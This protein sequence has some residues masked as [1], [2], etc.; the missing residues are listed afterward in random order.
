[1][2][3]TLAPARETAPKEILTGKPTRV[4]YVV[5]LSILEAMLGRSSKHLA[6][7]VDL[8]FGLFLVFLLEPCLG[9]RILGPRAPL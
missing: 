4:L 6:M 1:M 5:T 7:L 2:P 9:G 3:L 8:S